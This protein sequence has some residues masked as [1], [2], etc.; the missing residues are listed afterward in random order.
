MRIHK[1]QLHVA[2]QKQGASPEITLKFV[3]FGTQP[4]FSL[5]DTSV[6]YSR[7]NSC[8]ACQYNA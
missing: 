8:T 6:P 5:P 4:V 2:S 3:C 1:K 7:S